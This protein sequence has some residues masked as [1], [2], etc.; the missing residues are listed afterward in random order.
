MS[1][2]EFYPSGYNEDSVMYKQSHPILGTWSLNYFN[3]MSGTQP[4]KQTDQETG[5]YEIQWGQA[6]KVTLERGHK[7]YS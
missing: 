3:F 6:R 2:C 5:K 4:E 1:S 7:E